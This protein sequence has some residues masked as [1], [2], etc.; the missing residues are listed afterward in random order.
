MQKSL[1]CGTP[2][3]E[4]RGVPLEQGVEMAPPVDKRALRAIE[5]LKTPHP[6][7]PERCYTATEAMKKTGA[8][9]TTLYR[10]LAKQQGDRNNG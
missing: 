9:K 6:K 7:H 1:A 2:I 5:L 8:K 4:Y 3:W 10:H